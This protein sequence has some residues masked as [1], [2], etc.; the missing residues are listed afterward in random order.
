MFGIG[1]LIAGALGFGAASAGGIGVLGAIGAGISAFSAIG[2]YQG[3]RTQ[4]KQYKE[5][6]GRLKVEADRVNKRNILQQKMVD[7]QRRRNIAKS[8]ALQGGY[9]G[10]GAFEWSDK[11]RE[12]FNPVGTI[13]NSP[14]GA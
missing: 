12:G 5:Q 10:R 4:K 2:Q 14:I 9:R 8:K 7:E 13:G 11:F 6:Q 3:R 1:A